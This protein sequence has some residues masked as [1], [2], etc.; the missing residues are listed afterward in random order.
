MEK[1][2]EEEEEKH[3]TEQNKKCIY[4]INYDGKQRKMPNIRTRSI[5]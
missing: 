1:L 5:A 4:R 2:T 3:D